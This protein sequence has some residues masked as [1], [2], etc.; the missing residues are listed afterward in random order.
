M[1][2]GAQNGTAAEGIWFWLGRMSGFLMEL[3]VSMM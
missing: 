3:D 1:Q 2:D